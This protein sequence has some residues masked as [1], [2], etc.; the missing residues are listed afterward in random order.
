MPPLPLKA[1]LRPPSPCFSPSPS[2]LPSAQELLADNHNLCVELVSLLTLPSS[3]SQLEPQLL[4]R[5]KTWATTRYEALLR[6]ITDQIEPEIAS[7]A[8]PVAAKALPTAALVCVKRLMREGGLERAAR[9]ASW[10]HL[11]TL[12]SECLRIVAAP[13]VQSK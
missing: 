9:L 11:M 4:T 13:F 6:S 12:E 3:P 5:M 2:L 8:F 10:R 7:L 1:F